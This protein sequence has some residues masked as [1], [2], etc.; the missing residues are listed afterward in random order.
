MAAAI[1]ASFPPT[2]PSTVFSRCDHVPAT[3]SR[4]KN[5]DCLADI[6]WRA[7]VQRPAGPVDGVVE[8]GVSDTEVFG[9]LN[10]SDDIL[11]MVDEAHRSHTK[12]AHATLMASMPNAARIGFTGTPI[13]MGDKKRTESIFG[14]FLDKY[15]GDCGSI[16]EGGTRRSPL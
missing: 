10:E 16:I 5:L 1:K 4:R 12:T 9:V 2:S 11:V 3:G 14:G 6:F 7:A 15:G 8:G 13:I